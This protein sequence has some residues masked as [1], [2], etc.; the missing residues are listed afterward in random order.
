MTV[1][2]S[3]VERVLRNTTLGEVVRDRM[4]YEPSTKIV[5]FVSTSM[6]QEELQALFEEVAG[7]PDV[8]IAFRGIPPGK[9]LRQAALAI[10]ELAGGVEPAPNVK[11]SAT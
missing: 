5:V 2:S 10:A 3:A 8:V 4:E 11:A 1:S 7:Q 6:K 9:G